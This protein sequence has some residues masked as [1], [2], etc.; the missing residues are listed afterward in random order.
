[1]RSLRQVGLIAAVLGPSFG[2]G[3]A[4]HRWAPPANEARFDWFSYEG[5]DSVY[6]TLEV[7]PTRYTNP[8]LSGFYPDP[9]MIRVGD[10]YYLVTSSFAYFPGLPIFQ[11]KDLV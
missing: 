4:A 1:M 7:G 3:M 10:S 8:I 6:K 2:L 9:S 11:S 5:S